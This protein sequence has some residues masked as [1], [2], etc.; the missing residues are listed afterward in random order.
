MA[1]ALEHKQTS[2]NVPDVGTHVT[3]GVP[4]YN[5]ANYLERAL[6]SLADQT[7]PDVRVLISDNASTDATEEI[8]R[9][10]VAADNRF[11][12]WRNDTNIGAVPNYDK[13][14]YAATTMTSE[15]AV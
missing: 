6:S 8:A 7:Y 1:G 10:F 12:Y 4:V 15:D 9:S 5:G 11:E 14:F 3:I 2:G 13:V